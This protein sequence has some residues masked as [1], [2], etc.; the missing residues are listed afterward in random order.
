M[1]QYI[2]KNKKIW[3]K[4]LFSLVCIVMF[5]MSSCKKNSINTNSDIVFS[6]DTLMF[7]TLFATLGSTT[8]SFTIRN[9]QKKEIILNSIQLVGGVNSPYRMNVDGDVG[10]NFSNIKIP[11]KDSIYVFVEV[12]IDPNSAPLPFIVEDSILFALDGNTYQVQLNTYGK[13]CT[14]YLCRFNRK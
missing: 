2:S 11:A 1:L 13:K 10:T 9:T 12:T 6:T 7:D 5:F 14:F 4:G 3:I 8:K